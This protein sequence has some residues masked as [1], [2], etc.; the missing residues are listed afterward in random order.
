[1]E[2]DC[3]CDVLQKITQTL[4]GIAFPGKIH[5]IFSFQFIRNVVAFESR[6]KFCFSTSY[7]LKTKKQNSHDSVPLRLS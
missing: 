6:T 4:I 7:D 1:M 3:G 5:W 2:K